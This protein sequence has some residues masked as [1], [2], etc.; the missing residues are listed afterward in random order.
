MFKFWKN[1]QYDFR[2]KDS[3]IDCRR[4]IRE[5]LFA[6]YLDIY[7]RLFAAACTLGC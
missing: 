1:A 6:L 2:L 3:K 7:Q 4:L 5:R